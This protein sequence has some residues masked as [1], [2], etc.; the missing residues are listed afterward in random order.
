MAIE[1]RFPDV[2]EGIVEGEI[3]RW[4]VKEGDRVKAD[5]P[6]VEVE[7]DKALVELPAPKAGTVLRI[8]AREGQVIKVGQV[9]AV[10][11]EP[12]ELPSEPEPKPQQESVTVVGT[13]EGTPEE[14]PIAHEPIP[15]PRAGEEKVR[16]I[17][18]VR[19]L[20]QELGVDLAQVKG[21]G[22]DG[23]ILRED[24]L[25]AAE[26]HPF[27]D[28][29]I[30][31]HEPD[32]PA[33]VGE[34]EPPAEPEQH[35]LTE[36]PEPPAA[37]HQVD[38]PVERLALSRLRR[39][40]AATMVQSL[41]T[42]P[43]VSTHDE[44]EVSRLIETLKQ[45][46]TRA[47]AQGI[48][49]TLLPFIIKG[50]IAG[51]RAEPFLNAELDMDAGFAVLKKYYHIGIATDTPEGLLVPVIRHADRKGIFDLAREITELN[52]KAHRRTATLTELRGST[53]TITNYG[54]LGGIFGTPIINPPEVAILGL[55]R[56]Q[57][58]PVAREG[59]VVIRPL[60]PLS[61][62]FDHRLIDGA[63]A[64]RFLNILMAHLQDPDR[65]F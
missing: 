3:R 45:K 53:F 34:V 37:A 50:V 31:P 33:A 15:P 62:S 55:G 64:Q 49:L 23:R 9:V 19:K 54:A 44:V 32:K 51:L 8:C 25:R 63:T 13:L 30:V 40:I 65:L 56:V 5:Q 17:P 20:A 26:A 21:G 24:V 1:C 39:T 11:G 14:L 41:F 12:G 35:L 48:H 18:S 57:D 61:L 36:K 16:A 6:V 4:L 42:A 60:L 28:E 7:T 52:E 27:R 2:G 22:A 58:K 29:P 46:R 38:E 47:E 10:I 43:H 59:Q